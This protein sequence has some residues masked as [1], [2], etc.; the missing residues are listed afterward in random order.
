MQPPAD[1]G[2]N[3]QYPASP[4]AS[5]KPVKTPPSG[6][7]STDPAQIN[8]NVSTNFG[9]VGIQPLNSES[10]CAVNSFTSPAKQ[11]FFDNTECGRLVDAPD[12]GSLVCGGPDNEGS[13]GPG[14]EFA[15]EYPSNQYPPGDPAL[16]ATVLYP[17]GTVAMTTNGPNTNGSQFF[18][19]YRD[20]ELLPQYTVFGTVDEA[21]LATLDKIAKVGVAGN[22]HSGLPASTVTIN[23]VRLG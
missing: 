6:R 15:D 9:D 2:A 21:G 7:V 14:Y 4:D 8:A 22:R 23:S 10:P 11:Q 19:V 16:K 1:P 5:T 17:R 13:G 18:M 3:C 12:E 20:A